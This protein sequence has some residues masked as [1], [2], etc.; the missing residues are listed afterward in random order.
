MLKSKRALLVL[1]A[2]AILSA[3]N[4]GGPAYSSTP[5]PIP[6]PSPSPSPTPNQVVAAGTLA[7]SLNIISSMNNGTT[8]SS[9]LLSGTTTNLKTI[10]TGN[11][12]WVAAGAT[13]GVILVS[14]DGIKFT[15][16]NLIGSTGAAP[17]E[18]NT[19]YFD[20]S[21]F[22]LGTN[23]GAIYYSNASA[24]IWTPA[25]SP[26]SGVTSITKGNGV[27]VA[28]GGTKYSTSTDG[29]TWTAPATITDAVNLSAITYD[30]VHNLFIAAD[31]G[32]GGGI[33]TSPASA[34]AWTHSY[35][36]TTAGVTRVIATDGNGNTVT[37]GD[38]ATSNLGGRSTTNGT[39]W[40]AITVP[41]AVQIVNIYGATYD[42]VHSKFVLIGN[43]VASPFN[44]TVLTNTSVSNWATPTVTRS[45]VTNTTAAVTSASG[46]TS[47]EGK[48]YFATSNLA[49]AIFYTS[50]YS[51]YSNSIS[52]Y[53]VNQIIDTPS[54]LLATGS[55]PLFNGTSPIL[56]SSDKGVTWSVNSASGVN[57]SSTSS[58][59]GIANLNGSYL[60]VKNTFSGNE[61]N[62]FYTSTDGSTWTSVVAPTGFISSQFYFT[63]RLISANGLFLLSTSPNGAG[64]GNIFTSVDGKTWTLWW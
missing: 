3:C 32:A 38:V 48:T 46:V 26:M 29:I 25:A 15:P 28:V 9:S 44:L 18:V 64:S 21:K 14:T 20:G 16:I 37:F 43:A 8:W 59:R 45:T 4:G 39:T 58:L 34:I 41:T 63:G 12:V 1:A 57:S 23:Y 51:T 33:F 31:E 56:K 47:S 6:S 27:Y 10:A 5:T 7:N 22:L 60:S 54:G 17:A 24:T 55:A 19:I 2:S 52:G 50:D 62:S 30:S 61:S 13:G 42:S 35:T 36:A 11:G 53:T 40:T 49:G